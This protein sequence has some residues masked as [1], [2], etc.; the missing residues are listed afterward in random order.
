MKQFIRN[1]TREYIVRYLIK[2]PGE[3]RFGSYRFLPIF[4]LL[5]AGLEY[6][7]IH[8]TVG[9]RK[10]NFCNYYFLIFRPQPHY[11]SFYLKILP[12]TTLK[13][14]QAVEA[15]NEKE[16]LESYFN[17]LPTQK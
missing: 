15:I 14:R 9:P 2:I 11:F 12:D 10:V 16:K 6:L 5:G 1:F 7:M 8:L 13:R 17:S 4:F 3:K